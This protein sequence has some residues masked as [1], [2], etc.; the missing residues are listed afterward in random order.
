[1]PQKDV[2]VE[3][4]YVATDSIK[5]LYSAAVVNYSSVN[6][7]IKNGFVDTTLLSPISIVG[8]N[9]GKQ[10]NIL[11]M[12][13]PNMQ[14]DSFAYHLDLYECQK[15][16]C[17]K[18]TF[19]DSA[20]Y[21]L[22]KHWSRE[23]GYP[24]FVDS[25]HNPIYK[26]RFV[27]HQDTAEIFTNANSSIKHFPSVQ[28]T[29]FI[30]WYKFGNFYTTKRDLITSD[31][32]FRWQDSLVLAA[33]KGSEE[34][35]RVDAA[36]CIDYMFDFQKDYSDT[37]K[38]YYE[39]NNMVWPSYDTES[40]QTRDCLDDNNDGILNWDDPTSTEYT[41][42][43]R[44]ALARI[45]E[46]MGTTSIVNGFYKENLQ[47]SNRMSKT[48]YI[49]GAQIGSPYVVLDVRGRVVQ[50]NSV[51]MSNFRGFCSLCGGVGRSLSSGFLLFPG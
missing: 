44:D 26:V 3:N 51:K 32:L 14:T 15:Q 37:Y 34:K 1:M 22:K 27:I 12:S 19:Y 20:S 7:T 4:F 38:A 25:A 35:A 49:S 10:E 23:D 28:T 17:L 21:A 11:F 5:S 31:Y 2:V 18:G 16:G 8:E 47:V 13:A 30:G 45:K 36:Y 43:M 50:K 42:T 46:S 9:L 40:V 33:Y 41:K 29:D 48:I 39:K 24:I 6:A